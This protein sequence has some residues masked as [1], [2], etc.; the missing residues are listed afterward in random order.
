MRLQVPRLHRVACLL[1]LGVCLGVPARAD[2]AEYLK[3]PE[4]A[5]KWTLQGTRDAEGVSVTTLSLT[6]QTWQG[7]EWKHRLLFYVPKQ[8]RFPRFCTLINTG[9]DSDS[10]SDALGVPLAKATG[11]PFAVLLSIPNQPLFGD[12]TEDDLVAYTWRKYM[13]TGDESWPLHFPMAKAVLKAM[14]ALQAYTKEANKPVPLSFLITGA[15]KR[16]WTTWLVG[17]SRDRR[18]RAIAPMVIDVLNVVAQMKH[19]KEVYGTLSEQVDDYSKTGTAE[20]LTTPQGKRLMELEDPYSYRDILTLPKLLLLGTNDRYWSQ[21][22]LNLYWDDLKGPKWVLY[23]PNSGHGLEDRTRAFGTLAAFVRC[24][25]AGKPFPRISWSYTGSPD[26]VDLAI[27]ATPV[28][29]SARLFRATSATQ[30]FRDSK[31]TSEP[32]EQDKASFEG[33]LAAAKGAYTACYGEATFDLD[34][35]PFTLSTQIRILPPAP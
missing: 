27:S 26:K 15:S 19:Q 1:V 20:A 10:S 29:K 4:P 6:S 16:G 34:G 21:D 3:R 28:P 11:A 2:L 25:A 24:V 22:S 31:W 17:A 32:M 5:Y 23:V 18:V 30:D 35:M 8:V 9:G 13:E 7:I 14:D 33:T 12:R